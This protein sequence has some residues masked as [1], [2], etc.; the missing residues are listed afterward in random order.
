VDVS[1]RTLYE[2]PNFDAWA[3]SCLGGATTDADLEAALAEIEGLSDED[4]RRE[5][6]S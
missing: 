6:A 1:V 3:R 5:L 4:V 2:T